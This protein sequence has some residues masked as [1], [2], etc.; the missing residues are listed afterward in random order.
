M[1]LYAYA[2]RVARRRQLVARVRRSWTRRARAPVGRASAF[3]P[4]HGAADL[5]RTEVFAGADNSAR[6]LADGT[7]EVLGRKLTYPP[8]DWSD[9]GLERLR[10][11]HLHYGEEILAAAR[12]GSTRALDAAA[13]G[14][15]AWIAGNPPGRGDA[16]HP[17][18]VSTRVGNWIAAL[19]LEPA[20]VTPEVVDSLGRQLAFLERNVEDDILGNHVIRNARALVL[21]GSA[22]S[23]AR[24]LRRGLKL[25]ERELPEQVLSDGGHYERSPTYHAI[26]LRD[27]VEISAVA[28]SP[29]V[30]EAKGR[31]LEAAS[32][33]AR[34]DGYP[35]L[36]ND[37]GLDLAPDLTGLLCDPP[38]GLAVLPEMGYAVIRTHRLWL[39]FDCG[40][41]GPRFLPAHAHADALSFELWVDG[42]P[43]VV[44]PGTLTY[45][46][47]S[48]RSWFRSTRAHSTLSIDGCDHFTLWGAFRSGPL[49]S[50]RLLDWESDGERGSIAASVVGGALAK[51]VEHVR[52]ISWTA[53]DVAVEDLIKGTGRHAVASVL[54]FAPGIEPVGG[55][56]VEAGPVEITADGALPLSVE[57]RRVSGCFFESHEAAALVASGHLRLSAALGWRIRVHRPH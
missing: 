51:G 39:G 36:F 28:E 26:V 17:Y 55:D 37:G 32:I 50:V 16:W 8:R 25:L 47:G 49:P 54:Q 27:L 21:G 9:P 6:E 19:T 3:R 56:T 18:V 1:Q 15:Q 13:G 12:A 53:G 29:V 30:E 2:L 33:L 38:R 41:P 24:I 34:P 57:R 52:R 5:W 23:N 42:N 43:V 4:V 35:P 45:E 40:P 20:L 48:D 46:A 31:M 44:D 14:L 22:F 10:R 11:F 7:I